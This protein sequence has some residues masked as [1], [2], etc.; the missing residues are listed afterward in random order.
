MIA[1]NFSKPSIATFDAHNSKPCGNRDAAW[2]FRRE[3][4][5]VAEVFSTTDCGCG[6]ASVMKLQCVAFRIDDQQQVEAMRANGYGDVVAE[7]LSTKTPAPVEAVA[8]VDQVF[9]DGR[10]PIGDLSLAIKRLHCIMCQSLF[11]AVGDLRYFGWYMNDHEIDGEAR[12]LMNTFMQ[13]YEDG[14]IRHAGSYFYR[15]PWDCKAEQEKY[16]FNGKTYDQM[17]DAEKKECIRLAKL[18]ECATEHAHQMV[19]E[20][21]DS[22]E[23]ASGDDGEA[24]PVVGV[25]IS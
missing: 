14:D 21:V 9:I 4:C 25:V 16:R 22:E 1:V 10:A 7:I 18:G 23:A 3:Q 13:S 17:S 15:I 6:A 2:K 12:T 20:V 19:Q 11:N 5:F 8:I 24:I